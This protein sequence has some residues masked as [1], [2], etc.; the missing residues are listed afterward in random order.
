MAPVFLFS[1]GKMGLSLIVPGLMQNFSPSS[2][3]TMVVTPF[4]QAV[5]HTM[6]PLAFPTQSFKLWVIGHPLPG[7]FTFEIILPFVLN[8]S[9]PPSGYTI[10]TT[11]SCS[12]LPLSH[13]HHPSLMSFFFSPLFV[14]RFFPKIKR[15]Q[16]LI[17]PLAGA[18][19]EKE[20]N[21]VMA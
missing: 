14:R 3:M 16:L 2:L 19:S 18:C 15:G 9:L 12:S 4:V 17:G 7:K 11:D 8:N 21:H 20:I 6:L 10:Y 5:R 1:F 13:L